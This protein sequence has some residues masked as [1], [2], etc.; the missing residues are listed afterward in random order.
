[1]L[2]EGRRRVV[3]APRPPG[4]PSRRPPQCSARARS[5]NWTSP[6]SRPWPTRCPARR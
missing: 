2:A 3:Q 5:R 1:M 6:P 4:R